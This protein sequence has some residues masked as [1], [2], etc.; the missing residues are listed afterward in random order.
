VGRGDHMV[1][2]W[3]TGPTS[4]PT[5]QCRIEPKIAI[6]LGISRGRTARFLKTIMAKDAL[7]AHARDELGTSETSTARPVQAA[8]AEHLL[9][10]AIFGIAV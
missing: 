2:I 1:E 8:L 3:L 10:G 5:L 4:S 9:F 7:G 6:G